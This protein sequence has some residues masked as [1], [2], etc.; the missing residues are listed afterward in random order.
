MTLPGAQHLQGV[1]ALIRALMSQMTYPP[2]A[3]GSNNQETK[4]QNG[5]KQKREPR[6][7][8]GLRVFADL[9][10][11]L[12][13]THHAGLAGGAV[14]ARQGSASLGRLQELQLLG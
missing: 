8:A 13:N 1:S 9:R 14:A 11:G 10:S 3:P 4:F 12:A 2:L 7:K 6:Q 5:P